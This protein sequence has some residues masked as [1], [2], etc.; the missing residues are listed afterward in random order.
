MPPN[1]PAAV[2]TH[3]G[4]IT[5]IIGGANRVPLTRS[6][7]RADS[8]KS[9]ADA[10]TPTPKSGAPLQYLDHIVSRNFFASRFADN[11]AKDSR[12]DKRSLR[13]LPDAIQN[14]LACDTNGND[15][16]LSKVSVSL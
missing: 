4:M 15:E 9:G 3:Q 13:V 2:L 14:V 11:C 10:E 12:N 7:K 16:K 5:G 8:R 6:R 1:T